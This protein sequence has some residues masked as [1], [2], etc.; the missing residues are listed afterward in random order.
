V[1]E[2]TGAFRKWIKD[3]TCLNEDI[4]I[5]FAKTELEHLKNKSRGVLLITDLE[6]NKINI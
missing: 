4:A 5:S 6:C 3:Y 1:E 2:D